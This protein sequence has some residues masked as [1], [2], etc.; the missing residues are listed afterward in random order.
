MRIAAWAYDADLHCTECA[1]KRF[2]HYLNTLPEALEDRE[3][4]AVTPVYCNQW[5]E[6]LPCCCVDCLCEIGL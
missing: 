2:G 5:D 3:G 1:E 4:N 6:D